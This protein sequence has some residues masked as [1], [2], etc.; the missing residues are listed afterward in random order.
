MTNVL[1][2]RR[3]ASGLA[4]C[5]LLLLVTAPGRADLVPVALDPAGP[6]VLSF[7]GSLTYDAATGNVHSTMTPLSYSAG[8]AVAL[9]TGPGQTVIDLFVDQAGAFVAS[10]TGFRLTGTVSV[11]GVDI[12]GDDA[13]P[14][15]FGRI[16]AFGSEAPGPPTR[17]LDGLFVIE[18]GRLTGGGGFPLGGPGG[19]LLF[20]E[21]VTSG[22]LGDFSHNFAS[23]SVKSDVGVIIPAP[24]AWALGLVGAALAA[25]WGVGQRRHARR[26]PGGPGP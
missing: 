13:N 23:D 25:A 14:L 10:G 5:V 20:A 9:F 4:A 12:T 19:F 17:T 8:G 22:T 26:G 21:T 16:T 24:A 3:A 1:S 15:L 7:N 18:G 6:V 11:N 2:L